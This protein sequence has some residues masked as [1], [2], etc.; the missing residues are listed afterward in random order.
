MVWFELINFDHKYV[1]SLI[2]LILLTL[3]LIFKLPKLQKE[4]KNRYQQIGIKI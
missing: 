4:I 1:S 3:I 2:L